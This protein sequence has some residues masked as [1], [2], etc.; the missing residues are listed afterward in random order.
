M[1]ANLSVARL[2][3]SSP[4]KSSASKEVIATHNHF[5]PGCN[6]YYPGYAPKCKDPTD[7]LCGK[8]LA[9]EFRK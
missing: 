2:E 6:L 9:E 3:V 8:C 4:R 5:C 1:V 7:L